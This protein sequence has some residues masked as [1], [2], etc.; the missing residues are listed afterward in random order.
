MVA[1]AAWDKCCTSMDKQ[2]VLSPLPV[3][4]CTP[5]RLPACRTARAR[6]ELLLRMH[7]PRT[8][9]GIS[10]G[11]VHRLK[12]RC[13]RWRRTASSPEG[14]AGLCRANQSAC[15]PLLAIGLCRPHYRCYYWVWRRYL[16]PTGHAT[17]RRELHINRL[18]V[19][20]AVVYLLSSSYKGNGS[21][22]CVRVC[23][24]ARPE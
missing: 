2:L 15:L 1:A 21:W 19:A 3:Y 8:S 16:L 20:L 11:L 14:R 9:P 17:G 13:T 23:V 22:V 24:R 4:L 12:G 7:T 5:L 6:A 10:R 18:V